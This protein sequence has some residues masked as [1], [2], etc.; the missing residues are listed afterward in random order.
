MKRKTLLSTACIVGM[1][2]AGYGL[3]RTVNPDAMLPVSGR[4]PAAPWFAPTGLSLSLA[5]SDQV[6]IRRG[7]W[8]MAPVPPPPPRPV[9]PPPPPQPVPVGIVAHS[10]RLRVV[11]MVPG[12]GEVTL[13][14]GDR[15]PGG[16]RI[17]S[18]DRFRIRWVDRDGKKREHEFFGDLLPAIGG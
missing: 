10:D 8:G 17:R 15:L 13:K 14:V 1:C 12:Q 2:A 9:P 6:W 18:I 7:P 11:F 5:A 4:T 3:E 16:G